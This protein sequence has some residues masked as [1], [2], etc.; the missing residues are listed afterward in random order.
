MHTLLQIFF[1]VSRRKSETCVFQHFNVEIV[2]LFRKLFQY[3]VNC[4]MILLVLINPDLVMWFLQLPD[5]VLT[6]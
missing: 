4:N 2:L 5:Y 3:C 6:K 1:Y